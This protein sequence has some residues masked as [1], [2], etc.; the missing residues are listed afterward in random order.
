MLGK[1]MEQ[2]TELKGLNCGCFVERRVKGQR[3]S[4]VKQHSLE[5]ETAGCREVNDNE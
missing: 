5:T 1:E 2:V 3:L 4:I